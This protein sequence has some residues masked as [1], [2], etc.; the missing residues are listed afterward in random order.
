M[1]KAINILLIAILSIIFI[2]LVLF[3]V[4]FAKDTIKGDNTT[5]ETKSKS[6]D[7]AKKDKV[8]NKSN[9]VSTSKTDTMNSNSSIENASQQQTNSNESNNTQQ[10]ENQQEPPGKNNFNQAAVDNSLDKAEQNLDQFD[11]DGDGR[12]EDSERTTTTDLLES[13]GRLNIYKDNN[14]GE[15]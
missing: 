15:K 13:Q 14:N 11:E 8:S 12:I 10:T 1:K 3:V 2:G 4:S 7:S 6:H 9:N 5:A